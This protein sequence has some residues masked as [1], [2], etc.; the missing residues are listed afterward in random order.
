M[1]AHSVVL[2]PY[3]SLDDFYSIDLQPLTVVFGRNN[4]GKSNTLRAIADLLSGQIS[5]ARAAGFSPNPPISEFGA[6]RFWVE[7]PEDGTVWDQSLR[8]DIYSS[9]IVN[10]LRSRLGRMTISGDTQMLLDGLA[11]K[12]LDELAWLVVHLESSYSGT[13]PI[14]LTFE[15]PE[16]TPASVAFRELLRRCLIAFGPSS[17]ACGFPDTV[18]DPELVE[19]VAEA[20]TDFIVETPDD[21]EVGM[22]ALSDYETAVLLANGSRYPLSR[23][24]PSLV[25]GDWEA[26]SITTEIETF[27][28]TTRQVDDTSVSWPEWARD[29]RPWLVSDRE[30]RGYKLNQ[31][32]LNFAAEIERTA[33]RFLPGFLNG[34]L[35]VVIVDAYWWDQGHSRVRVTFFE[36]GRDECAGDLSDEGSGVA[37]WAAMALRLAMHV[38]R[39]QIT[40]DADSIPDQRLL[41]GYVIML[42]EPEAHLHPAAVRD[43]VEWCKVTSSLGA[44][45]LVATHHEEFLNSLPLDAALI[46]IT[47][48]DRPTESHLR[49]LDMRTVKDLKQLAQDVGISPSTA[50]GLYKAVLFVEGPLDVAVLNEFAGRRL[51]AVGV[52]LVPIHGTRN[53]EGLVT[54]EV[55]QH[56]GCKQGILLDA[57]DVSTIRERPNK[58]LSTEE[59][60]VLRVLDIAR[61]QG[62]LQPRLFG[63]TVRDLLHSCDEDGLRDFGDPTFPGWAAI[64]REARDYFG[65]DGSQSVNWKRYVNERYRIPFET[66]DGV[67]QVIRWLDL[68]GFANETLAGLIDEIVAWATSAL[69]EHSGDTPL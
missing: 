68:H 7:A 67:R 63:V 55:I 26:D 3:R 59:K 13:D 39:N 25:S 49:Q 31:S 69:L 16:P 57:T 46:H 37:R 5:Q 8:R 34:T 10:E 30:A 60:K 64:D 29:Y 41:D 17:T 24:H 36:N 15:A 32:V 14:E 50:F 12:S 28:S 53:L 35:R 38:L 52:L 40:G 62:G 44:C 45:V 23:L 21:W 22:S 51:E 1:K 47:K 9:W 2:Y 65:V 19:L 58:R 11:A 56:L 4:A 33:N 61:E 20:S 18:L 27:I 66:E 43:V 6:G 54:S 48:P 42:D